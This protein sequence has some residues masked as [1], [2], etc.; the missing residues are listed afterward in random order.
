V[1]KKL[2]FIPVLAGCGSALPTAAPD[3]VATPGS[4][5][6]STE[7]ECRGITPLGGRTGSCE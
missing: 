3:D 2:R 1:K 4:A 7:G 6:M 5:L